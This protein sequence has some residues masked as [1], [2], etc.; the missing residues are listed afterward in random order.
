M[1]CI[2]MNKN[3]AVLKAD[4]DDA[5][6]SFIKIIEVSLFINIKFLI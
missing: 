3:N 6:G 5:T 2:L 4:Y 1:K